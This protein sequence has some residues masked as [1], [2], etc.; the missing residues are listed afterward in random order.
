MSVYNMVSGG[1]GLEINGLL[2]T[3]PVASGATVSAGD[4]VQI[5][6]TEATVATRDP[7]TTDDYQ[8]IGATKINETQILLAYA[9]SN[10]NVFAEVVTL[11]GSDFTYGTAVQISSNPCYTTINNLINARVIAVTLL[12][13]GSVLVVYPSFS[14]SAKPLYGILLQINGTTITVQ[15]ETLLVDVPQYCTYEILALSLAN[16]GALVVMDQA[17]TSS[18]ANLAVIA[19]Q[20][21]GNTITSGTL[22]TISTALAPASYNSL[23]SGYVAEYAYIFYSLNGTVTSSNGKCAVLNVMGT[24]I[25]VLTDIEIGTASTMNNIC[26]LPITQGKLFLAWSAGSLNVSAAIFTLNGTQITSSAATRILSGSNMGQYVNAAKLAFNHFFVNG[27]NQA[28]GVEVMGTALSTYS[29][30]STP[31]YQRTLLSLATNTACSIFVTTTATSQIYGRAIL[32]DFSVQPFVDQISGV[33]D[34]SGTSPA[35]VNVWVPN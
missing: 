15:S 33:A 17:N 7:L 9:V 20:V 21:S 26:V 19:L 31:V 11:S 30:T 23:F 3:I 12:T 34:S 28:V 24:D 29:S 14:S 27:Y 10:G 22:T 16:N 18:A 35:T 5:N 32:S 13:D 8:F 25:S 2:Q 6:T 1:G 4:F